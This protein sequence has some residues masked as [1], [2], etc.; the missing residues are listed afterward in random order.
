MNTLKIQAAA[1]SARGSS[2]AF[3][4]ALSAACLLIGIGGSY[5]SLFTPQALG[6]WPLSACLFVILLAWLLRKSRLQM[7]LPLL[8]IAAASAIGFW[9]FSLM[10]GMLAIVNR[11]SG[12]LG[13]HIG[14]N[15]SRFASSGAGEVYAMAV[16]AA[17]LGLGCVWL[18][19]ARSV[20]IA[21][22][23]ILPAL[24]LDLLLGLSASPQWIAL[25][26]AGVLLLHLPESVLFRDSGSALLAW[27]GFALFG[28]LVFGSFAVLLDNFEIPA[29]SAL[30]TELL[31]KIE[32]ARFG[33]TNLAGGD[34]SALDILEPSDEPMLEIT[35]LEPESLYL[36][37]F[38]GSEYHADGWK[39]ASNH[40]LS[41]G[42]DLFYW[43][44]QEDFFG[45]TQLAD[46]AL[47][48]DEELEESDLIEITVRHLGENRKYV[49]APYELAYSD[50]LDPAAIGD[51]QLKS[52][53]LTGTDGYTLVSA[54][55][56]VKRYA[57][58]LNPLRQAEG[59]PP[60]EV[61]QYLLNES[62]YN[63]FVY[64]H[65]LDLP[66]ETREL[67]SSLLGAANFGG[68]PH[69]DYGEAKQRILEW[70]ESN[71]SYRETTPPRLQ[72]SDFLNEFLKIN[73][74]GYDVHYASAATAMMRFFGIP[75]RYVEGYLI[76]PEDAENANA[77][78]PFTLSGE[79]AHAWC[80]I[81]QDGVGWVPFETTPKYLNLMEQSDMLRSSD[82]PQDG[83]APDA[84]DA[85][86]EENS[87]DMEEDFHDDF[88]DEENPDDNP[89]PLIY[90]A[91]AAMGLLALLLLALLVLRLSYRIAI[92]RLNRSLRLSDRKRAVNNLYSYLFVLMREIYGWKDCVAP[93]AFLENVRADQGEDAAVKFRQLIEI[94]EESA[95]GVH[96]VLEEDYRFVY[97]YVCKT[98][99][100][101]KK[102]AGFL[103]R[104]KL[105]YIRH[106]I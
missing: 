9:Q 48:L 21:S 13:A 84:Q 14:R 98:R 16:L 82:N 105:R 22:I 20:L 60:A 70:L 58:L 5:A 85:P 99:I 51:V 32:I 100:L 87:L 78:V 33:E 71:I 12:V 39:Q 3:A 90:L 91:Y 56:Q 104:Q 23:L 50:L 54:P 37:G 15:L 24:L 66:S 76:T 92:R 18:V 57:Y 26:F 25:M 72:G 28:L 102:R 47:L 11:I 55:N 103:R 64:K 2:F 45:Q 44:H 52:P 19:K 74:C 61:E 81:Y 68:E 77:G 80:E 75:A 95:F 73:Q 8:M 34:F 69:L 83:D 62:H 93:S 101:L 1:R 40:A 36:R 6:F 42:A 65:F 88:E 97:N 63:S 53:S 29:V 94:C 4:G 41:D 27:C 59:N 96:G 7:L 79:R 49:F 38:V 106:L 10:D 35:M 89:L 30:R 17:L 86:L 31:Q 46:A 43:L 67:L